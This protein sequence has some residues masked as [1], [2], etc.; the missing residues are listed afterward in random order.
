M[1][2]AVNTLDEMAKVIYRCQKCRL[3]RK[4][5]HAVPGEGSPDARIMFIGEAPGAEEDRTG[6]P[7]MGP[8][9][10]FL[11][12]LF[13]ANKI[14]RSAVFLTSC[15]K[16]RPPGNRD[17]RSRELNICTTTWLLPQIDLIKPKIIVL[18]G[19]IAARLLLKYPVRIADVHGTLRRHNG[20]GYFITYHPAV[21]L[22]FPKAASFMR[23]DFK[24]LA[25]LMAGI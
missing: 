21:G 17:P 16:C 12:Q 8:S 23:S 11:D 7:F 19:R 10:R 20:Q 15:V 24:I 1:N 22:R 6:R 2:P 3:H 5:L 14:R 13:T 18:C 9:G 25:G 4:R